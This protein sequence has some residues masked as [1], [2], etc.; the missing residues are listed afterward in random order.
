MNSDNSSAINS[1]SF[2]QV[3]EVGSM[4]TDGLLQDDGVPDYAKI[5]IK[6]QQALIATLMNMQQQQQESRYASTIS[7]F[8]QHQPHFLS[9]NDSSFP[10]PGIPTHPSPPPGIRPPVSPAPMSAPPPPPPGFRA[11]PGF[12]VSVNHRKF[13]LDSAKSDTSGSH[14]FDIREELKKAFALD[15]TNENDS[16]S[17]EQQNLSPRSQNI[18]EAQNARLPMSSSF[19]SIENL[20]N[21]T[22]LNQQ[23]SSSPV[24]ALSRQPIA[25]TVPSPQSASSSVCALPLNYVL[26]DQMV[27][28]YERVYEQKEKMASETLTM[29]DRQSSPERSIYQR[30]ANLGAVLY[31]LQRLHRLHPDG[32]TV[33]QYVQFENRQKRARPTSE[34]FFFNNTL[35]SVASLLES[36]DDLLRVDIKEE[37]FY[38]SEEVTQTHLFC[39]SKNLCSNLFRLLRRCSSNNA[40]RVQHLLEISSQLVPIGAPVPNSNALVDLCNRFPTIFKLRCSPQDNYRFDNSVVML[41]EQLLDS[42]NLAWR[43]VLD[44]DEF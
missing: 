39:L 31:I 17:A 8:Q 19:S 40:I 11:P 41:N 22:G 42:E 15:D 5:I 10:P 6:Q 2:D 25:A 37:K 26:V 13:E 23:D 4:A 7:L 38:V 21:F 3:S 28:N 34:G 24:S 14:K 12:D 27:L 18:R 20:Q 36:D 1:K 29:V 35:P 32:F 30:F 43:V 44:T 16:F 9:S 33:A